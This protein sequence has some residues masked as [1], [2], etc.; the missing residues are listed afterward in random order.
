MPKGID[1]IANIGYGQVCPME[2]NLISFNK[3]YII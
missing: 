3:Y 1:M 2:E